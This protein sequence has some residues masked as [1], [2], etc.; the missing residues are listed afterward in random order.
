MLAM[1][2]KN[3][4]FTLIELLIAVAIMGILA[5]IAVPSYTW[6]IARSKVKEAPSNLLQMA[7]LQEQFYRDFRR[8]AEDFS[9]AGAPATSNAAG[10]PNKDGMFAWGGVNNKYFDYTVTTQDDGQAYYIRA[11]GKTT[12]NLSA[13]LYTINSNNAKCMRDDGIDFMASFGF[14]T[15][16]CVAKTATAGA[17]PW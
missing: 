4:G 2:K 12:E 7:A 10:V 8:Y 11:V 16:A 13:Y 5:S 17:T 1:Y 14:A 15:T 9:D 6:Y 3:N